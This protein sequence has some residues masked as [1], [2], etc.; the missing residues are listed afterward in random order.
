MTDDMSESIGYICCDRQLSDNL[1][2]GHIEFPEGQTRRCIIQ[3]LPNDGDELR[4]RRFTR[5]A[6]LGLDVSRDHE[7]LISV[8]HFGVWRDGRLFIALDCIEGRAVSELMP[9][10]SGQFQAI[11]GII[12]T[13]LQALDYLHRCGVVHGGVVAG[14]ILVGEDGR[15]RLGN[16]TRAR[17]V[18]GASTSPI[19]IIGTGAQE[20]DFRALGLLLFE[21]LTGESAASVQARMSADRADESE[22]D[23]LL[24][25]VP[26]DTPVELL[27]MLTALLDGR[28]PMRRTDADGSDMA[29]VY[30]GHAL[31]STATVADLPHS[32]DPESA[33][34]QKSEDGG[35]TDDDESLVNHLMMLL[36]SLLESSREKWHSEMLDALDARLPARS[37]APVEAPPAPEAASERSLA[38]LW[39]PASVG[40]AVLAIAVAAFTVVREDRPVTPAP[41]PIAAPVAQTVAQVPR[42]P[43]PVGMVASEPEQT[44]LQ[45][46]TT[47][48][49]PQRR[50][51]EPVTGPQQTQRRAAEPTPILQEPVELKSAEDAERFAIGRHEVNPH[52]V[53]LSVTQGKKNDSNGSLALDVAVFNSSSSEFYVAQVQIQPSV[54]SSRFVRFAVESS[55]KCSK[56]GKVPAMARCTYT[57]W[58]DDPDT[59]QGESVT[60]TM[61]SPKGEDLAA[62]S[63]LQLP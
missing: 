38:W 3:F 42:V 7:H 21:L 46:P 49:N 32:L 60:L 12:R 16:F 41:A 54:Q 22:P 27:V 55:E 30:R 48:S 31:S 14:N 28:D 34:Q 11:A 19:G 43:T 50:L 35:L 47:T 59:V 10:L 62:I 26:D 2:F 36:A 24:D 6:M 53:L 33:P 13:V 40:L 25:L 56:D 37:A 61:R 51:A 45:T 57:V 39:G 1:F 44:P 15:I 29:V 5:E 9:H 63:G 23:S 4:R 8:M 58:I 20:S 52:G 18:K 17:R